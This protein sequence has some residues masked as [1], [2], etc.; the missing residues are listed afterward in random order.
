[1]LSLLLYTFKL[2]EERNDIRIYDKRVISNY[3]LLDF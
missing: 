3:D 1:M 2:S